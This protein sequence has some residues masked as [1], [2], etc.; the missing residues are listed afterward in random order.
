M[1]TRL[2]NAVDEKIR[3]SDTDA[4]IALLERLI[5]LERR[6]RF[7]SL[8]SSQFS[9]PPEQILASINEFI[10]RCE[11]D[12]RIRTVYIEMNGFDI[13]YDRWFY[14]LFGYDKYDSDPDDLDWLSE[15]QSDGESAI[16]LTGLEAAQADFA[17][18]CEE[19]SE[20]DSSYHR[21]HELANL[22]V[23]TKFVSL[24][25]S[26]LASGPLA[27]A[28]PVIATAHDFDI[29]G[30]FVPGGSGILG[31]IRSIFRR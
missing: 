9:N 27:K 26:A 5:S 25:R 29:A 18:Y 1:D 15:W 7:T 4:A 28:V 14:D 24:I 21:I 16:T 11:S 17:W 19:K 3:N 22:L 31:R 20:D 30:R 13:N 6:D 23:M 2:W 10:G 12:F 8:V